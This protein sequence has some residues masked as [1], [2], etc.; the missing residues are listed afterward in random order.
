MEDLNHSMTAPKT[1][2]PPGIFL[3][4]FQHSLGKAMAAIMWY[5]KCEGMRELIIMVTDWTA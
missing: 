4:D 2:P 5:G 1:F 3:S